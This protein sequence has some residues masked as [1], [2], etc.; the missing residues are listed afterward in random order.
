MGLY[1][2]YMQIKL[3][4]TTYIYTYIYLCIIYK[5][6]MKRSSFHFTF[7]YHYCNSSFNHKGLKTRQP[8]LTS[9]SL[10]LRV[11]LFWVLFIYLGTA[12]GIIDKIMSYLLI[13]LMFKF[14]LHC[15][16]PCNLGDLLCVS[17]SLSIKWG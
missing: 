15:F 13:L 5:I 17:V 16:Y 6:M 2:I 10:P 11:S 7:L 8:A 1:Q 12:W 14:Y 9:A 3:Y 4:K